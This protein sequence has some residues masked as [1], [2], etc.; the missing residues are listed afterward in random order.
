MQKKGNFGKPEKSP[1]FLGTK[2]ILDG[3][4]L[5][6]GFLRG[7]S[8]PF[9]GFLRPKFQ[10]V[11]ESPGTPRGFFGNFLGKN[12][13]FLT[14]MKPPIWGREKKIPLFC[15]RDFGETSKGFDLGVF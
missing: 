13:H 14:F 1:F 12:R 10:Y 5:N 4:K 9:L 11:D 15:T 3:K 8:K 7:D 6:L 2:T